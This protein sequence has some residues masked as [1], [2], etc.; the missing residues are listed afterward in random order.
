MSQLAF[1]ILRWL[2]RLSSLFFACVFLLIIVLEFLAPQSGPPSRLVDWAGAILLFVAV[3]G[4]IL[5]W[6]WDFTGALIALAALV[7]HVS[8]VRSRS[9][10]VIWFAAIPAALYLANWWLRRLRTPAG[11]TTT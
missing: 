1:V 4:L 8:V 6:K 10:A 9:Y 11:T 2:A 7:L 3:A 5:A